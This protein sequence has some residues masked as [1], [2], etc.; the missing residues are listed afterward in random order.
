MM[1]CARNELADVTEGSIDD[2][3]AYIRN[4]EWEFTNS[5]DELLEA[6]NLTYLKVKAA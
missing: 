2:Q 6:F 1:E 4:V 3:I 5:V